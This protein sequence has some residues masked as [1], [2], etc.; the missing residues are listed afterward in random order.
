MAFPTMVK[1]KQNFVLNKIADI[2]GEIRSALSRI[3]LQKIIL[4]GQRVAITAG[5]RGIHKIDVI[6]KALVDE[7]KS[8]HAEPFIV[9]AM[10]SHGGATAEGQRKVL[11][12]YGITEATM[13]VPIQ[14]SMEV[15]Q[16][17]EVLDGI[18]VFIDK[19]ALSADHIVV[20]NRVKPHTDFKGDIE[21]GLMKMIA[22]GLGKQ[23]A[24]DG[25]HNLFMKLGH[26]KLITA[27]AREAIRKCPIAFGLAL[28]ENQKDETHIIEGIPAH[29]IEAREKEL[30]VKSKELLPRIP[31][32]DID[33]LIVDEM[34][35]DFSGTGMDQNVIAR[36]VITYHMVTDRPKITRIF[37]RD[38][39]RH[40]GG[41]A[42]GIGNADFTTTRLVEKID[43]SS[44]YMNAITSS[45]PEGIRIPPHYGSDREAVEAALNTIPDSNSERVRIAHIKNTLHLDEMLISE[46]LLAEAE[47]NSAVSVVAGPGSMG[48]DDDGNIHYA[49]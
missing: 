12:S 39:S 25:Y 20:V 28:V 49:F 17:G 37:V 16:I 9:P 34:G 46:A 26:Y 11:E 22:I 2:P 43:R 18:P 7:L 29:D 21:S 40:S 31:F 1:I 5:S 41:N 8:I 24:A 15:V 14:S 32:D 27:V 10:G 33:L 44:S 48:F 47:G 35:K 36:T 4:P 42:I 45:G 30:L 6:L 23:H 19:N 3:E 38:L 13:G